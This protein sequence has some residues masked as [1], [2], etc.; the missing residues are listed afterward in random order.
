M[1]M[2]RILKALKKYL[3]PRE[4]NHHRPHLLR[5]RMVVFVIMLAFVVESVFLLGASYVVPRSKLFGIILV[6]V[7]VDGTNAARVANNMPALRV[8]PLLQVAAQK[9]ADDMV[10]NGYFAHTSPAGISPWYWFE[11]AGYNFSAAGENLAVDFSDS[12]DVT[13]AWMNSPGHRANI[14]NDGFTEIGM[15]TAQGTFEGR[16]AIYV[17]E[18]FGTPAVAPPPFVKTVAAA[19]APTAKPAPQNIAIAPTIP[20]TKFSEVAT[21]SEQGF[22]KGA[23]ITEPAPT[24]TPAPVTSQTNIVQKAAVDPRKVVDYF[25]LAIASIFAI[26]LLLNVFIKIHTQ[27]PQ[28]I[29][30]GMLVIMVAGL[31]V[32]LN[33]HIVLLHAAVL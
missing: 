4:E 10:M 9:K 12:A 1:H 29:L 17:V 21:A 5:P 22:A 27:H 20:V 11:Q 3:I 16:Q 23:A 15:A 25:Y 8:N 6:S 26:A 13:N 24:P 28:L 33:D 18:L 19:G 32:V 7:L 31:L 30:G 14:L 2:E